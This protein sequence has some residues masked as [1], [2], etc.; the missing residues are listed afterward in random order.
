M[1]KDSPIISF[2][3]STVEPDIMPKDILS[4]TTWLNKIS[5]FFNLLSKVKLYLKPEH[6]PP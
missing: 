5:F 6:P 4:I 3:K 1:T 2:L